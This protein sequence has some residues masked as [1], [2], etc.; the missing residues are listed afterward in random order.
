MMRKLIV[1][2]FTVS[3]ILIIILP[4]PIR[5]GFLF[6]EEKWHFAIDKY[7]FFCYNLPIN[8]R[9]WWNW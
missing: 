5:R 1:N 8:T 6:G 2:Y 7:Y 3:L 4:R 9:E